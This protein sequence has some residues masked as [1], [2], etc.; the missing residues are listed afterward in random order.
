[1]LHVFLKTAKFF[2]WLKLS[3]FYVD[4]NEDK[5]LR[6]KL[7]DFADTELINILCAEFNFK[8]PPI[9]ELKELKKSISEVR[10]GNKAKTTLQL[11][12]SVITI[13]S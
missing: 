8:P 13:Q 5:K 6:E 10:E 3:N 12:E 9:S 2:I 11:K 4:V 7:V 1:L